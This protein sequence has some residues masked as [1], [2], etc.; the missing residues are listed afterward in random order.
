MGSQRLI[1]CDFLKASS[2]TKLGNKVKLLYLIMLINSDDK[3]F[4]DTTDDII[5][6]LNSR[7]TQDGVV[8]LGLLNNDY[9]SALVE[10]LNNGYLYEFTD[11]YGNRVHLIRHWFI[12]NKYKNGLTTNYYKYLELVELRSGKYHIKKKSDI[13]EKKIN[14]NTINE[15]KLNQLQV[16]GDKLTDEEWNALLDEMQRASPNDEDESEVI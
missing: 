7:D 12:H 1:N 4:V 9:L 14:Q 3:G 10:L 6:K 11:D 8:S 5:D 13:K 15:I 2:F 16:K